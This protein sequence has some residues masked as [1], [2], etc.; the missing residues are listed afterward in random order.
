MCSWHVKAAGRVQLAYESSWHTESGVFPGLD[1]AVV[2]LH[3]YV[4]CITFKALPCDTQQAVCPFEADPTPPPQPHLSP[5]S[6]AHGLPPNPAKAAI[7][8]RMGADPALWRG[9]RPLA[10]DL[11][12]YAV[13]DV[14]QLLELA[15]ELGY[16]LGDAGEEVVERL[17]QAHAGG[18]AG[19]HERWVCGISACVQRSSRW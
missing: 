9:A 15:D 18:L 17:S 2:V 19:G 5:R 4:A 1:V 8:K 6:Q 11:L 10:G 16:Q 14:R 7:K 13:G 3:G 12:E